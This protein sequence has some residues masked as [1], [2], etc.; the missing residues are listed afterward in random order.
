MADTAI[1]VIVEWPT[2]DQTKKQ[3]QTRENLD[4][5]GGRAREKTKLLQGVR[6]NEQKISVDNFYQQY[7]LLN[8]NTHA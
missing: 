2:V 8:K 1:N 4:V 3:K 5:H 6:K 7:F